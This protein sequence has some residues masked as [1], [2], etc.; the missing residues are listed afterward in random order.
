MIRV[1]CQSPGAAAMHPLS[2]LGGRAGALPAALG[3]AL[4]CL[5]AGCGESDR[6]PLGTVTG[7]VTLDG[8]P[9][10][11]A[12]VL[13]TPE[14]PGRTAIGTTDASGGYRLAYLRDIAGANL[15]P[16]AVRITTA[17]DEAGRKEILPPRYHRQSEL[18]AVVEPGDNVID[19]T[20]QSE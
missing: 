1:H 4:L 17:D 14:G 11:E 10:A 8:V 18:V 3:M 2:S 16:H 13:F 12:L 5:A 20:L 9:L 6:P 7:T 19:F 15:G